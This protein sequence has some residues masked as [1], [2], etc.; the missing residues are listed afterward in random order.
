MAAAKV[1]AAKKEAQTLSRKRRTKSG[2]G[3]G[4]QSSKC[5]AVSGAPKMDAEEAL[6]QLILVRPLANNIGFEHRNQRE[7]IGC[8]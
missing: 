4:L 2:L 6:L 8:G 5:R 1:R 7:A 3:C